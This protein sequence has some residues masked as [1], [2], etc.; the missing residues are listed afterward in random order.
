MALGAAV[1]L[2]AGCA[3]GSGGTGG[4]CG[5][6][7]IDPGEACDGDVVAQGSNCADEGF[8]DG[9]PTCVDDCSMLNYTDCPA[10]DECGND[11]VA[12]GEDCD[13]TNLGDE[14][15]DDFPNRTGRGLICTDECTFDPGACM[16]CFEH[17]E[18]CMTV[19]DTCCEPGDVC[20]S[21]AK[22]CCPPSGLGLCAL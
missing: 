15:C 21:V 18:P 5:D 7:V 22:V 4:E 9:T 12:H 16:A 13:G 20:V 10:Y 1:Y 3:T 8:G 2:V 6:G 14:T 19:E 17:M 11:E